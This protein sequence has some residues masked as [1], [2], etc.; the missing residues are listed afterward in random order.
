MCLLI[1]AGVIHVHINRVS[2]GVIRLVDRLC[3]GAGDDRAGRTVG[4]GDEDADTRAAG[5][6][7]DLIKS[8]EEVGVSGNR[9]A[10]E[11]LAAGVLLIGT[12]QGSGRGSWGAGGLP[13]ARSRPAQ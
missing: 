2:G 11:V 6:G 3:N 12:R 1:I 4:I 7:I 9:F 8:R 13:A 5:T 10:G